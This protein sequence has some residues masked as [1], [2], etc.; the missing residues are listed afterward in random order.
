MSGKGSWVPAH[1]SRQFKLS[2]TRNG[3]PPESPRFR[4]GEEPEPETHCRP[5]RDLPVLPVGRPD[6]D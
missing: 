6:A 4:L 3:W 5:D 2:A 1:A